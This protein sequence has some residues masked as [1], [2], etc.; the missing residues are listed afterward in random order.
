MP[1]FTNK[2]QKT[3]FFYALF[4]SFLYLPLTLGI[5]DTNLFIQYQSFN[6]IV[7]TSFTITFITAINYKLILSIKNLEN[8]FINKFVLVPLN[9]FLILI[10]FFILPFPIDEKVFLFSS[11]FLL[12]PWLIFFLPLW[13]NHN[14]AY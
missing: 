13:K 2:Y 3:G 14:S 5:V 11:I 8:L 10:M 6:I 1:L 12:I 4:L 9:L 7:F